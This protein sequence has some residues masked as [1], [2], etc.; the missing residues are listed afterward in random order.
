MLR[1]T[2]SESRLIGATELALILLLAC[3]SPLK[4][5]SYLENVGI[6]TFTTSVPVENGFINAGSGNLHLEIP[7]GSFPQRGGRQYR[8]ALVY[9]SA[10]W[11]PVNGSW[12]P[13][14]VS[15]ADGSA[16]SWGG[17]RLVTSGD[18]GIV[19]PSS[20]ATNCY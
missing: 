10:I 5:Q 14:N 12:Q 2:F 11:Q 4:A 19:H 18:L 16:N 9:D 6:P 7:L 15:T 3:V 17:W 8:V 20:P 13:T 1:K